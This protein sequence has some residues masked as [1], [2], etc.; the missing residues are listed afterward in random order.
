MMRFGLIRSTGRRIHAH[1]RDALAFAETE[2]EDGAATLDPL[3]EIGASD[4]S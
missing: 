2:R 1:R 4:A 3:I